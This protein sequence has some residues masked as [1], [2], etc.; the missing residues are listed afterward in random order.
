MSCIDIKSYVVKFYRKNKLYSALKEK[1]FLNMRSFIIRLLFIFD[2]SL[3]YFKVEELSTSHFFEIS[4][5]NIIHKTL[6]FTT[7]NQ[8][9]YIS[10]ISQMLY[11][12]IL[13]N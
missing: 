13:C 4:S 5:L 6:V 1:T 12:I 7:I 9:Y 10:F 8:F 2:S 11:S 3:L